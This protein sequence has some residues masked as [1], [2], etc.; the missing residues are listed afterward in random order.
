M[1]PRYPQFRKELRNVQLYY[2]CDNNKAIET[3]QDKPQLHCW[4]N[5]SFGFIDTIDT[6]C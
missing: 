2:L 4:E 1:Q 3:H 6:E 5:F